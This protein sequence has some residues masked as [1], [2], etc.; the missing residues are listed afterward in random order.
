MWHKVN[1]EV[2]DVIYMDCPDPF[3]GKVKCQECKHYIDKSDAQKISYISMYG[4]REFFYC[5]MHKKPYD[6]YTCFRM[7]THYYRKLLVNEEGEPIGYKKVE[8]KKS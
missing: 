1:N 5:P 8:E 3:K 2:Q 6:E 7:N 4:G